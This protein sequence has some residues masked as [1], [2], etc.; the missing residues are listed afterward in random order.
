MS[1]PKDINVSRRL[2]EQAEQLEN[3]AL[4]AE[5]RSSFQLNGV[6][7][8][9]LGELVKFLR[10]KLGDIRLANL[11]AR[12]D[13]IDNILKELKADLRAREE[14]GRPTRVI[15]AMVWEAENERG[16]VMASLTHVVGTPTKYLSF[17]RSGEPQRFES[18]PVIH[19]FFR[20]VEHSY[21]AEALEI[22]ERSQGGGYEFESD[23]LARSIYP[24][25]ERSTWDIDA[26]DEPDNQI[27]YLVR[28]PAELRFQQTI[29]NRV[30]GNLR[31]ASEQLG[32]PAD[33]SYYEDFRAHRR[34]WE[35][36]SMETYFSPELLQTDDGEYGSYEDDPIFYDD[37]ESEE[38]ESLEYEDSE[39]ADL[40]RFFEDVDDDI[41]DDEYE[42]LDEYESYESIEDE[43]F[44]RLENEIDALELQRD[45]EQ[46]ELEVDDLTDLLEE[47]L[48]D[49]E[50]LDELELEEDFTAEALDDGGDVLAELEP[51]E[52]EDL[53][54]ELAELEVDEESDDEDLEA[55]LAEL[56]VDE[57]ELDEE[58]ED[59]D[60]EAELAELEVDEEELD[61]ESEDEALEA[62]LAELEVDEEE[63]DEESEDEELEAELAE[64]E[65]DEEELDEESGD[66]DLDAELAELEV[67]DE[68]LEEEDLEDEDLDDAELAELE[69][70][71]EELDEE[72]GDEDL[73]AELAELEADE[74]GLDEE[75]GDEDLDAELAELE[76]DD[77][78]LDEESEDEDLDTELAELEVD[79]EELAELEV[80]EEDLED[81]DVDDAELAELEDDDEDLEDDDLEDAELAELEDDDEDLDDEDLEDDE[82]AELEDEEEDLD[83]ED[84]DDDDLDDEEL[85]ELEIDE[86]DLDDE[87]L[88]DD[89]LDDAELAELEDDDED[90][91]DDDLDDEELAELEDDEESLED[92]DI[93]D[94]ELAELNAEELEA[95]LAELNDEELGELEI[96]D[97]E[98]DALSADELEA[99]LAD[100]DDNLGVED[101]LLAGVDELTAES[102]LGPPAAELTAPTDAGAGELLGAPALAD[103]ADVL[104]SGPAT[105]SPI[106]EDFFSGPA[107]APPLDDSEFASQDFDEDLDDEEFEEDDDFIDDLDPMDEIDEEPALEAPTKEYRSSILEALRKVQRGDEAQTRADVLSVLEAA[108]PAE[109][110]KVV[111]ERRR[112]VRLSCEY[113]VN[114]YQGNQIF[115]ATIQDISLGGM[116]IEVSRQLE[117]GS[118]LEVSNP[119]R[120][121]G[122]EDQRV[123]AQVRWF[124]VNNSGKAEAGLQFVDPPE[125]LGRSWV[126][127]LLNRVGMQSQ[128]FNQRKYTRAVADFPVDIV[129]EEEDVYEGRCVDLGLGGALV[130]TAPGFEIGEI[131]TFRCLSFGIHGRLEAESKIV[132]IKEMNEDYGTYAL[133]FQNLDAATTKLLGRYVV[134]LLK[135]G[136]SPRKR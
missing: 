34:P 94:E 33:R 110:R 72:S 28:R 135:L 136:R 109:M 20:G 81:E 79:D 18:I 106:D 7:E 9:E 5:S 78:E 10:G 17:H 76:A 63:L 97:K 71:E 75:S 55:E 29:S 46:D 51:D 93:D 96:D 35:M 6:E 45:I 38:Y 62:E 31:S 120:T 57:E 13:D 21:S 88:D 70:D 105:E 64:L 43:V 100:L 114:C 53:E 66:E 59:E 125:V 132:K 133:E 115:H 50:F 74:E 101:E 15:E 24:S 27:D 14:S 30:H 102:Q 39:L 99:E 118:Q 2:R 113:D 112:L 91:E 130:D 80:D 36:E 44:S 122:Q 107:D 41:E 108:V 87:D 42:E 84:L 95:E 3:L 127:S 22:L 103:D 129:T 12:L 77:K 104:F 90:L 58:S 26:I 47:D 83:E 68:E 116:K 69:I 92:E 1:E 98:L 128:V 37:Y 16:R 60:L 4:E 73:D 61:E 40:Q 49:E 123:T 124:R 11:R 52:D 86:E 126:V 119:N 67:D 48:D 8:E 19:G 89:D 117:Q 111:S 56:E 82:L 32:L 131:V 54:D 85:A 25:F 65:V 23:E 134:D 121:E